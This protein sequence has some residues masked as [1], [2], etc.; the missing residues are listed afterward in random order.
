MPYTEEPHLSAPEAS[1]A[2]TA[3]QHFEVSPDEAGQRLDNYVQKRLGGIPRSRVY[4]V[5]R[6]G[7][8]RVNGKRADPETR[9]NVNDRITGLLGTLATTHADLIQPWGGVKELDVD[10]FTGDEDR[11]VKTVLGFMEQLH[12]AE[13]AHAPQRNLLRVG[14]VLRTSMS[15]HFR[16]SVPPWGNECG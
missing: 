8:V 9:L 6:K 10:G 12:A 15:A 4:R 14:V 16:G 5:I 2:R 13:A 3:V 1:P 11:F 7:E